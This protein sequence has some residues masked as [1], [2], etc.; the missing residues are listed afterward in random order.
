ME[1]SSVDQV[2]QGISGV[3]DR[4][5][6]SE[7]E[8][9]AAGVASTLGIFGKLSR[10]S[11]KRQASL[12]TKNIQQFWTSPDSPIIDGVLGETG[13][14]KFAKAFNTISRDDTRLSTGDRGK[15]IIMMFADEADLPSR[16]ELQAEARAFE[17]INDQK[18]EFVATPAK[19]L[20]NMD[21]DIKLVAN[22]KVAESKE[23]E[24]ALTLEKARVYLSFFPDLVDK[25][26]LAAQI[27]EKFGDDPTKIFT[28]QTIQSVISQ[29]ADKQ[30]IQQPESTLPQGTQA[31]NTAQAAGGLLS[32]AGNGANPFL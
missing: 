9:A 2:S 10:S 29:G 25:K 13:K 5:T 20:R 6:A 19:Y 3:G 12:R 16:G 8:T 14:K 28:E 22:V 17:M 24:K 30:V 4:T 7:I 21:F 26:E 11:I 31:E 27:A 15:K 23:S 32:N 18:I 1:E